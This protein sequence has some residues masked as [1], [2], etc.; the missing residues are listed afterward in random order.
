MGVENYEVTIGL[1]VHAQLSTITKAWCSCEIQS[2]AEENSKVC[3]VCSAQPGTLPVLNKKAR[4]FAVMLGLATDCKINE[5]SYFDRKNYFYPDLPKGYQITQFEKPICEDGFLTIDEEEG[6]HTVGIERIQMEE[7]TAK[8]THE[9]EYSLINFNRC[10]T[11]LIEIVGRP[12]IKNK[13]QAVKYLKKLHSILTYL[14][15]CDGNLQ[16]GNFRCDV[17]ISLAPTGSKKLGTR[18]ETKNLNSFRSVERLIEIEIERQASL[19]DSGKAIQ[20]QT[21]AFDVNTGEISVLRTKSDAHDYRYFPEPDLLPLVITQ[22]EITALKGKLPEL[23]GEKK[24][25]LIEEYK[26]PAYDAE[27]FTTSRQLSN[28]FEEAVK[29]YEGEDAKKVSN[30]IMVE[31]FKFLNE[32]SLDITKSPV[33]AQ[34]VS[35]LLNLV[36]KGD[37]SGKM[38]KEVFQVMFDSKKDAAVVVEELGL[39]QISD[40]S[41]IEKI[42]DDVIQVNTKEHDRYRN[43]EKKLYGFFVGQVMKAS[44]GQANPKVVNQLL[45]KRL[46][47]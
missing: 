39:K 7:D 17:N 3:E 45:K 28:F 2:Y 5:L 41:A 32:S 11:P 46:D 16:E 27:F 26:L 38:A 9:G 36:N 29:S 18:T 25:R 1:E 10:G 14:D 22:P 8:S 34:G 15:I 37:I 13:E 20:Q 31:L 21:L 43:G 30:W 12:H 42:I 33:S 23:P 24:Q 4:D 6:T 47:A 40:N 35:D 19:L 44:A